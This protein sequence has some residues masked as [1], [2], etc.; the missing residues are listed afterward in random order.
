VLDSNEIVAEVSRRIRR[1]KRG[2]YA[3]ECNKL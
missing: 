3:E 1:G 2:G